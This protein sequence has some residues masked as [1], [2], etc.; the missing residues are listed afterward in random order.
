MFAFSFFLSFFFFPPISECLFFKITISCFSVIY[1]IVTFLYRYLFIN[2]V[3]CLIRFCFVAVNGMFVFL[4]LFLFRFDLPLCL[5]HVCRALLIKGETKRGSITGAASRNR[6]IICICVYACIFM[7]THRSF[8]AQ[9]E[10][11]RS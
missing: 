4:L 3:L 10:C 9:L 8:D 1:S 7:Y 11:R 6:M 5:C 2:N